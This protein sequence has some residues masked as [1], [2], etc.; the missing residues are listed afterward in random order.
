MNALTSWQIDVAHYYSTLEVV[1]AVVAIVILIFSL[2]DLLIDA[3]YWT[4]TLYRRLTKQRRPG[5]RP[6]TPEQIKERAEQPLAIMVPAWL[7]YHVIGPMIQNM[8]SVLDYRDY[9]I[10]VGTY[11]NDAAT[12]GEVEQMRRRYRQLKRIEVPHPGPTCK[13]DCLNWIIQAIFLHEQEHGVQFAGVVLHDSEDVLHPLELQLFNYLLPD[14]DMI[15]LPVFSLYRQ[16]YELVAG[17]YMDEFAEWHSKDLVA[18]ESICGTVPSAGVGTCFSRRA[19]KALAAQNHNQPFSTESLTE[20]YDIGARLAALGMHSTFAR[21]PVQLQTSRP[22]WFGLGP[23]RHLTLNVALCVREYFPNTFRA[24][25][26][27]KARW[28]LGIGFQSWEQLGW[29]GSLVIKYLLF[30]DRKSIVTSFVTIFAY[31]VLIQFVLLYLL[32][33]S[34]VWTLRFPPAFSEKSWI[35]VV[36]TL[37]AIALGLRVVQRFYFV[38]RIYG[39]EQGLMSIPRMVI[40]NAINAMAAAR[41]WRLYLA[42][43][44]SGKPLVWDKTTHVFPST[45]QLAQ[46]PKPLGELLLAWQVID[47]EQL[48]AALDEQARQHAPLGHVLIAK[49]WL[50]DE[51]LAEAIAFQKDL[52]RAHIDT[53]ALQAH[54]GALPLAECVRWRALPI[55]PDRKGYFQL[56]VASPLAD[57]TRQALQAQL[58][59]PVAFVIASESQI[60]A[61]LSLLSVN[62]RVSQYHPTPLRGGEPAIRVA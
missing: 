26:R 22:S 29:R 18:R 53:N 49:G 48:Q 17:T 32:T 6:L 46:Q 19:L 62:A 42:Q 13:A 2:D 52:P 8:V 14:T 33:S 23:V 41:A 38:T 12:I 61:G 51:T 34:G 47:A 21:F 15:Q 7:E 37:V 30:R 54:A 35:T 11:V 55:G 28:T 40:G 45:T 16:W 39:W 60:D 31:L 4:L 27:Q 58:G 50:D 3:W 10:F 56:A 57:D 5:Y 44:L 24:A 25:Y 59:Q 20:D 1:T 9:V 36:I 43:V